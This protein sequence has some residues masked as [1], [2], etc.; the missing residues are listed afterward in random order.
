MSNVNLRKYA[1]SGYL[2]HDSDLHKDVDVEIDTTWLGTMNNI[3]NENKE[4]LDQQ[5][6][7]SFN[8]QIV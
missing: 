1:T 5:N 3:D 4:C 2:V 8:L 6:T 7:M